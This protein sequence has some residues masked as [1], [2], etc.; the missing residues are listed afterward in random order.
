[1]SV[2]RKRVTMQKREE[3]LVGV[4]KGPMR[5]ETNALLRKRPYLQRVVVLGI[6]QQASLLMRNFL[7]RVRFVKRNCSTIPGLDRPLQNQKHMSVHI[8]L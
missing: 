2:T 3:A 1:M 6:E 5:Q 4:E 8:N 7:R